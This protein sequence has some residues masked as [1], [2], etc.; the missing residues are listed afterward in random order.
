MD[1]PLQEPRRTIGSITKDLQ[2]FPFASPLAWPERRQ[3]TI[4]MD[5]ELRRWPDIGAR[6]ICGKVLPTWPLL[7]KA[8]ILLVN[9]RSNVCAPAATDSPDRAWTNQR[10]FLSGSR[11]AANALA[12]PRWAWTPI[13][14]SMFL[15][16]GD[17]RLSNLRQ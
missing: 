5:A 3:G 10:F 11:N 8:R 7:T 2:T 16:R 12:S 15:V 6:P 14:C 4:G 17:K 1:T 13:V 9:R